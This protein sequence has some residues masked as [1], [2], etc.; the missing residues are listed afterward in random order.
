M[1]GLLI[2]PAL[3]AFPLMFGLA[4][5]TQTV[6]GAEKMAPLQIDL[7]KPSFGGSP[8]DYWSDNMEQEDFRDRP[9]L[10][11]PKGT[12]VVSLYR[13][14][15]SSATVPLYGDLKMIVDGDKNYYKGCVVE[16]PE[17]LHWVQIDL[18]APREIYAIL[19]WHYFAE[20]RVYFDVIV[21]VSDDPDFKTGVTTLYSNDADNTSKLGAGEDKEYLENN[22][23]RLVNAKGVTARYVRSYSN[24]NSF[25]KKNHYIEMEVFGRPIPANTP[26][27]SLN[28]TEKEEEKEPLRIDLPM[29]GFG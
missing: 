15:S 23:G 19:I 28:E 2:C 24:G 18:Q 21:Q 17:G 14:V 16:L 27:Q 6:N 13:P 29:P 1:K 22:K 3:L 4:S 10:M 20:K 12:K 25:D 5:G 11:A 26:A 8:V 7:P 9:P